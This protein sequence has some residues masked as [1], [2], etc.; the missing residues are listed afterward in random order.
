[1][2]LA[3]A[4]DGGA[5]AVANV[6]AP[7]LGDRLKVLRPEWLGQARWSQRLSDKGIA[8][9]LLRWH[10]GH[11]LDGRRIGLLWNRI[12]LLPQASFRASTAQDRDYAG[13]EL[14]A[15]VAS[16]LAELGERVEPAMRR[17]ACVTPVLHHLRWTGVA[18][19]CGLV[20]AAGPSTPEGLPEDFSVLRTPMELWGP[21]MHAWPTA[22]T[23][24]CH[25]MAGELGFALL[26]LG[27]RGTPAAPSLC[28]VDAHPALLSPGEAQAVAR[29]L[30]HRFDTA[31][32]AN[33][34]AI[35][36]AIT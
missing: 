35:E 15:L 9:T 23:R 6:L 25:A 7:V 12:R 32:N 11:S 21:L 36:E 33:A 8:R 27:F 10:G 3:H 17:H 20:L 13:A 4:F 14:Q 28:R 2:I 16:W 26:S 5:L 19:R 29:W 18:S 30:S 22:F 1:M 31:A 24:A 34:Q